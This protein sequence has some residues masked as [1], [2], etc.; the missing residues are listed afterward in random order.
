MTK[1]HND[2][3]TVVMRRWTKEEMNFFFAIIAKARENQ[4]KIL[5]FESIELKELTH[6]SGDY[7]QRWNDI[8]DRVTDK[9][10]QL[11]Y[12]ER[13][14]KKKVV[15]TLFKKF[16]VDFESQNVTISISDEFEYILNQLNANFTSFE[17]EEFTKIRSTYAKT[18][19]RILKQWRTQGIK[20]FRKE[21][22]HELLD[23]PKSYAQSDI[24]KRVLKPI[25][26]ELTNYFKGLKVNLKKAKTRG[27]PITGYC[28][29]WQAEKTGEWKDF[30]ELRMKKTPIRTETI[31]E[32]ILA[33]E[34]E[35]QERKKKLQEEFF[36]KAMQLRDRSFDEQAQLFSEAREVDT[37]RMPNATQFLD[38]L[39]TLMSF[40]LK[41]YWDPILQKAQSE[42]EENG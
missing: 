1:Y 23:I 34:K 29:T 12:K 20:E 31:P 14:S 39:A 37:Y 7:N 17:L 19:Y 22:F 35:D 3:N 2:L 42:G 21:E 28:F 6:F 24:N 41:K 16:E 11:I 32:Q 40:D 8:M 18:T 10:A 38:T 25:Q 9:V 27:N 33:V 5:K 26:E 36:Q 4:T 15:M 13:T 30:E